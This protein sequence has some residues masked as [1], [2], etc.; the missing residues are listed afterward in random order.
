ME[1]SQEMF[2][3]YSFDIIMVYLYSEWV[4]TI[5]LML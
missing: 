1:V 2:F 5:V 3:T 4:K